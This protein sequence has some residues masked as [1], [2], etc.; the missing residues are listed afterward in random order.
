MRRP[1]AGGGARSAPSRPTTL[2]GASSC[3][4]GPGTAAAALAPTNGWVTGSVE[5]A[6]GAG[7]SVREHA[8]ASTNRSR[9]DAVSTE[10]A[11]I[12]ATNGTRRRAA[13]RNRALLRLAQGAVFSQS[14]AVEVE[15][16]CAAPLSSYVFQAIVSERAKP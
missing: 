6:P 4:G 9:L 10:R 12:E 3:G 14:T 2:A 1:A 5:L 11:R 8:T 16:G 7:W 15:L 13:A